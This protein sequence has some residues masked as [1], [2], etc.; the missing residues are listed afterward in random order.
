MGQTDQAA[1]IAVAVRA[2]LGALADDDAGARPRQQAGDH[3]GDVDM[4]LA[5]QQGR[6]PFRAQ[7]R[8][9]GA[10]RLQGAVPLEID[11]RH[12]LGNER[13]QL[14]GRLHQ[15]Q[16]RPRAHGRQAARQVEHHPLGAAGAQVMHEDGDARRWLVWGSGHGVLL[17]ATCALFGSFP[18][19]RHRR[20]AGGPQGGGRVNQACGTVK[21]T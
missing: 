1:A 3:R 12:G 4:D 19:C 7:V 11:D 9:Q 10:D 13:H 8:R 17:E 15:H 20:P 14:P 18:A 21:P 5:G 6:G 2:R 16:V